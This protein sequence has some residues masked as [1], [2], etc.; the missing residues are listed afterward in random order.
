MVS[1]IY[2]FG[3]F[4]CFYWRN[5]SRLCKCFIKNA[6]LKNFAKFTGRSLCWSLFLK[7][8]R[9]CILCIIRVWSVFC[10]VRI[11]ISLHFL[12]FL[13]VKLGC[14]RLSC[15]YIFGFSFYVLLYVLSLTCIIREYNRGWLNGELRSVE[16]YGLW[17]HIWRVKVSW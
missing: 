5:S 14:F 2:L 1:K 7:G 11:Y 6:V 9:S 3:Y 13:M 17:R 16:S 8:L 10:L 4:S 15:F 12:P